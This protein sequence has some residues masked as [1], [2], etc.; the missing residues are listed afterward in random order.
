MDPG[1]PKRSSE[2]TVRIEKILESS[3]CLDEREEI[4]SR[5]AQALVEK[6]FPAEGLQP[7]DKELVLDSGEGEVRF[8]IEM[9]VLVES[10]PA[11][12]V[13]CL[14]GNLNT[15]ER[16]SVSLA[17]LLYDQ[18]IPFAVVANQYDL[19]V[20]N[21]LTGRTV[22]QGFDSLPGPDLVQEKLDQAKGF[23]LSSKNKEQE[24]RILDTYYHLRCASSCE[25]F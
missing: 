18:P 19:V 15:R 9:L 25:P 3:S 7:W 24:I 22:G 14:R 11:I 8:P 16:A 23:L 1:D 2:K 10:R 21:S 20:L 13:K 17:R 12:L 4:R 5:V 6:G